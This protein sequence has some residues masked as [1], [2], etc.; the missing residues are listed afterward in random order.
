MDL[1]AARTMRATMEDY[2]DECY[3]KGDMD[4]WREWRNRDTVLR[5]YLEIKAAKEKAVE[6]LET[7]KE[8]SNEETAEEAVT[9]EEATEEA[10]E[11]A[12]TGVEATEE[13]ATEEAAAVSTDA[14]AAECDECEVTV[15][16]MKRLVEHMEETHENPCCSECKIPAELMD[17]LMIHMKIEHEGISLEFRCDACGM[18]TDSVNDLRSHIE[19]EHEKEE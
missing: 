14:A 8:D 9:G 11:E 16:L 6:T 15:N 4:G 19:R 7:V 12:A 5:K 13:A 18:K 17:R 2:A 10:A 3:E 1:D